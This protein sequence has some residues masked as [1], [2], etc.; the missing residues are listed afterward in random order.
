M[1]KPVKE[2]L[3]E[4]TGALEKLTKEHAE[5]EVHIGLEEHKAAEELENKVKQLSSAVVEVVNL[6]DQGAEID[7]LTEIMQ[8]FALPTTP[9]QTLEALRMPL[10]ISHTS[11]NHQLPFS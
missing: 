3:Q 8:E 2:W 10:A 1:D 11:R 4:S 5:H 7:E 6:K 9:P